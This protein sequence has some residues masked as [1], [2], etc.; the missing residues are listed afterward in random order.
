[1]DL[2]ILFSAL[3]SLIDVRETE[4]ERDEP[5]R[6][7]NARRFFS[8]RDGRT[9]PVDG[10]R[11]VA[12]STK[13]GGKNYIWNP[14]LTNDQRNRFFYQQFEYPRRRPDSWQELEAARLGIREWPKAVGFYNAGD[15]FEITP[16]MHWRLHRMNHE[17]DFWTPHDNEQTIVHMMP[18]VA[19][20]P[21]KFLPRVDTV[22]ENHVKRFGGDHVIYNAVM[23]AYAFAKRMDKC[24]QLLKEM[25]AAHLVP[26]GQT[27]VNM[28][29]ACRLCG[30]GK[31]RAFM[32][33]EEAIR[34]GSL[35]AVVRLDTEFQMWW[36]QLERLGSFTDPPA[37]GGFLSV[38]EEGAKPRPS[39]VWAIAGWSKD[40]R[41]FMTLEDRVAVQ[42]REFRASRRHS[43]GTVTSGLRRQPWYRFQG[44]TRH[45]FVGPQMP[46]EKRDEALAFFA[47]APPSQF[48]TS[49]AP[50]A[51]AA[52]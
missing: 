43:V 40:E 34:I 22:F 27:F 47:G 51:Y 13:R 35:T 1:M 20:E 52:Q 14:K 28:M 23:Q 36:D 39:D 16:E 31:E 4:R 12:A 19:K 8:R 29:L 11:S 32:Y 2:E 48:P 49:K 44:Y 24:E 26:N 5:Q 3:S 17:A 33:F 6:C 21:A 15:N 30:Q 45:D 25:K 42:G 46:S 38:D 9:T 18:L 10:R 37:T 50:K 7:F 41:K